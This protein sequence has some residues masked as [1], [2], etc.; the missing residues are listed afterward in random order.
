MD[1]QQWVQAYD[2]AV[3]IVQ[4]IAQ[5]QGNQAQVYEFFRINV[6]RLNEELLSILPTVFADLTQQNEPTMIASLFVHFG[7]L[8]NQFPLGSRMLNLEM[9]ISA[10]DQ[11]LQVYTRDAFPEDWART[12]NNLGIAYRNRIKGDIIIN[13]EQSIKKYNFALEI[14]TYTNFPKP[15]ADVQ[16]NLGVVYKNL[17]TGNKRENLSRAIEY[18]ESALSIITPTDYSK[19]WAMIQHNLANTYLENAKINND[20]EENLKRAAE[21]CNFALEVFT[22]NNTYQYLEAGTHVGLGNIY[23]EM[24]GDK[25]YNIDLAVKEYQLA[26]RC[27]TEID[28]PEQWAGTHNNLG[29][30]YAVRNGEKNIES[31]IDSYSKALTIFTPD[32]IPDECRNTSRS[33]ANLYSDQTRWIEADS[34][35]QTALQAAEICYQRSAFLESKSTELFQTDDLPR[36]AAYAYA[37][38]GN[39]NQAIVTLESSRARGP[40]ESLNRNANL[41]QLQ[42]LAPHLYTQYQYLTQQIRNLECQQRDRIVSADRH[43]LTPE[44]LRNTVTKLQSDLEAT[45]AQIRQVFGYEDF[46]TP[47]KWENI[48][49]A[50]TIDRPLVYFVTTPNGGMALIVTVDSIEV[51]W[52]ND[53][54]EETLREILF[55]PAEEKE[56][57]RYLGAY[58]DF[59]NDSKANYPAWCKEIDTTTRQLWDLLMG[60]IVQQL[61]AKGYDRATLIP[62]G[63]LSLLPLHAAWIKDDDRPTKKRYALDDIHFTYI[64]NA[65][66][67]TEARKIADRPFTDSILAI[68]DPS[69]GLPDISILKNSQREIDCAI[70]SFS[71][72]AIDLRHDNATIAAVK[73][74]L[75]KAAIVH[76][77][78]HGTANF[79]EPLN[80]GLLMSDGLL[81][82]KD[83]LALNLAQDSGIR[84]AIL[85]A[86][87][88]GLPGLDNID[89][90]VSLPIG[91]LQAGVAGVISSLWSVDD[92]STMM[93]LTRFY[94]LWRKDGLEPSIA[95]REAQ[96]WLR[97]TTAQEKKELY[98]HFM[99]RKSTLNDRT[100]EHPFHWAAFSYLGV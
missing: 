12:Q 81:T 35:Y 66:S 98:S 97:D 58:Q 95:L 78:C 4:L 3:E 82:L 68:D 7:G 72:R 77:S 88:T 55:G 5:M 31:A 40:S 43:S 36:R 91:L 80:S 65:R 16:K 70:D 17:N 23:K 50:V 10:Y 64:P 51:L 42:P 69:H 94:D 90:V 45:I 57:S 1:E 14:Y 83:L 25:D 44:I 56:L 20:K 100:C 24:I 21:A 92:A 27:Y 2:L 48:Q 18:Y 54:E 38:T 79:T 85:S 99:F 53:L 86:C 93:L 32:I 63:Y 49:K 37:K 47:I 11:A 30:A 41:N 52:L 60:P 73:S 74:G 13:L 33:L 28:F 15:W 9:S 96:I 71:D 61:K 76:F 46:L 19:D 22:K 29:L 26:L 89:E 6:E 87:E 75:T 39:F 34:I 84:L 8:I 59:R 62:T 67:L